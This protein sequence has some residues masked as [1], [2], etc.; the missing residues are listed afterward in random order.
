MLRCHPRGRLAVD[1]ISTEASAFF[2]TSASRGFRGLVSSSE[3]SR[4]VS[5]WASYIP[6]RTVFPCFQ[7]SFQFTRFS[8]LLAAV[9]CAESLPTASLALYTLPPAHTPPLQAAIADLCYCVPAPITS[10]WL[11]RLVLY[12]PEVCRSGR[13]ILSTILFTLEMGV[14]AWLAR[15]RTGF[16]KCFAAIPVDALRSLRYRPSPPISFRLVPRGGYRPRVLFD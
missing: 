5:I 11:C 4:N 1:R 3:T 16:A 2:L 15:C 10:C 13:L 8:L 12:C 9:P 7:V 6:K 14:G